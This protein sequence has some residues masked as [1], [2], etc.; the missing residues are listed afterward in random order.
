M[1]IIPLRTEC[2]KETHHMEAKI[3]HLEFIQETINRMASNSF[4]LKGWVVAVVGA[5][6]TL[7]LKEI[8]CLYILT[9][10]CVLFF[11]WLLDS[12]YLS[13]EKAFRN[14]YDQVRKKAEGQIDFSMNIKECKGDNTVTDCAFSHTVLLFYGGLAVVHIIIL[15]FL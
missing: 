7:S 5:L 12:Y 4:L 11:F 6:V 9:S 10:L 8:D 14:L 15:I 3:K 2:T 13:R 1:M